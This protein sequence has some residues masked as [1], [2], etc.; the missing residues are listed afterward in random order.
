MYGAMPVKLS[1]CSCA[2]RI[3][4]LRFRVTG[5]R[6]QGFRILRELTHSSGVLDV[7][8]E[9]LGDAVL[10]LPCRGAAPSEQ[11]RL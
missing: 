5:F 8:A 10:D 7:V 9:K 4:G 1:Y 2:F 6:V 3:Q 11:S